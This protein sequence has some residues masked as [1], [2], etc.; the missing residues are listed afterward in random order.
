MR[1]DRALL[2]PEVVTLCLNLNGL[3]S[4]IWR[5]LL[6]EHLGSA[7]WDGDCARYGLD[8]GTLRQ[9]RTTGLEQAS[10]LLRA[11]LSPRLFYA[12]SALAV[13]FRAGAGWPSTP[14][15]VCM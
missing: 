6:A 3:F 2:K 11:L 7:S 8:Q 5:C 15:G 4:A 1:C 10:Q 14:F 12:F 13:R 9:T